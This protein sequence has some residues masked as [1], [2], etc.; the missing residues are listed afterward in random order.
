MKFFLSLIGMSAVNRGPYDYN[1]E[2]ETE[3]DSESDSD[4]G[5]DNDAPQRPAQQS[6]DGHAVS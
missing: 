3:S 4:S 5:P 1:S 2:S 6:D